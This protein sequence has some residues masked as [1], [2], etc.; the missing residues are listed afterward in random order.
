M[1]ATMTLPAIT[2]IVLS[3]SWRWAV[4]AAGAALLALVVRRR[5]R[6]AAPYALLALALVTAM[7]VTWHFA[8]AP[9]YELA[10]KIKE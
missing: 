6:I 1:G 8:Q 9:M 4:P 10:D 5:P 7:L 2:H 3:P